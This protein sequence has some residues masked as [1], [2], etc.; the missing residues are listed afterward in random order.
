MIANKI[1]PLLGSILYLYTYKITLLFSLILVPLVVAAI[2][3]NIALSYSIGIASFVLF[4]ML[5]NVKILS[6][7]LHH[8]KMRQLEL[9]YQKA[10][11]EI[12]ILEN[13]RKK[14]QME[15]ASKEEHLNSYIK[16]LEKIKTIE[17]SHIEEI[18]TLEKRKF[19]SELLM[20]FH[21]YED[22]ISKQNDFIDSL[23]GYYQAEKIPSSF[24]YQMRFYSD[25][26][27]KITLET[28][29]LE[30]NKEEFKKFID[31]YLNET[32]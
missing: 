30:Q 2:S 15:L 29:H 18:R 12:D 26:I 22:S 4:V 32:R 27:N 9:Q 11:A 16:N 3:N 10:V 5:R 31:K 20:L 14:L 13:S 28:K 8:M 6:K 21:V 25:V 19:A 24:K 7:G 17:I 23:K 1:K